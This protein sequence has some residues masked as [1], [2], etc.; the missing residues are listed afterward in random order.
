MTCMSGT[1][2]D[3][4]KV[5]DALIVG[6]GVVGCAIARTLSMYKL[7]TALIEKDSDVAEGISKANSGVLHAGFN[8]PPGTLK[9]KFNVE[10]LDYFPKICEELDV[11]YRLSKKL[12]IAKNDEELQYLE[13]LLKQGNENSC[14]GLSIIGEEEI[15]RIEPHAKGK[16]ALYSER[17]AI[18]SPYEFTI[19]L[20]ESAAENGVEIFLRSKVTA[21]TK[22][23]YGNFVV[24]IENKSELSAKFLI[25]AAGVCSDEISA[26]AGD[27]KQTVFPCR[28]EYYIVDEKA[29]H[30][31]NTA[32]YPVP[33]ADGRGL[34]VHLTPTING[35]ILIGPSAEY[36]DERFN[37]SNT[38]DVME[39]LKR[40]AFELLPELKGAVFIKN[41]AGIRPKLW[42][43]GSDVSFR[44]FVIEE[45]SEV[46]LLINLIGIESPGL[47]SAPAIADYVV[48]EL[49]GKKTELIPKEDH[50]RTREG[51]KRTRF[52]KTEELDELCK[53]DSDYGEVICRCGQV[54][55]GEI[56]KALKNR[57]GSMTLNAIKKR[58]HS[59]MGRCQ[60]GFCTP[61]IVEIMRD[62]FGFAPAEIVKNSFESN[63]FTGLEN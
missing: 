1:R 9:A 13:K 46:P 10:G 52:L 37:V 14:K 45:S 12:V 54:S 60:G 27:L 47:T 38:K 32:I 24:T 23:R 49:I 28:G 43:H 39:R 36:I 50:I 31:L 42:R 44:D 20:A 4:G 26:M 29:G 56:V 58:T 53:I 59:M 8:Q 51:I 17:T 61:K 7:D 62:D 48:L 18:I 25:N 16:Y 5:Y 55:K 11:P 30:L 21:V 15:S 33:P 35:N 3:S 34:G 6:G 57:R 2:E 19:A 41:Y 40:E 63:L 22:N